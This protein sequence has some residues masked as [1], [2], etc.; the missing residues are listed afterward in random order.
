MSGKREFDEIK[1]I[2]ARLDELAVAI[3]FMSRLPVPFR[4]VPIARAAW[5]FPAAGALIGLISGGVLWGAD[6]AGLP[7]LA[8]AVLALA[9]GALATGALH[10]DGLA[11]CADGFWGGTTPERRLEIMRDSRSGAFG[12]LALILVSAFKAALIAD[13]TVNYG[14]AITLVT[15]VAVHALARAWLPTVMHLVP[16]AGKTGLAA[17]A[18]QPTISVAIAA[19]VLGVAIAGTALWGGSLQALIGVT[20]ASAVAV[21]AVAALAHRKLK[22][23]NGDSLGGM[24]QMAEVA[25]LTALVMIGF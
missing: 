9:A 24:E 22:G 2:G 11:D 10:E 8:A 4:D 23:I 7:A 12:V 3:G 18:G 1:G 15:L 16:T 17:M 14:G 13:M 6:A 25:G 20:V 19:I 5:G 21:A